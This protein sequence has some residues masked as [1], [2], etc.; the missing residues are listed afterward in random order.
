MSRAAA[1][2]LMELTSP[3]VLEHVVKKSRFIASASNVKSAA[4]ARAFI[5]LVRQPDASHNCWASRISDS[6][7]R[8]SDDGEPS[9]TAGKPIHGA[10]CFSDVKSVA[11]VVTRYFGG[12]KL[13][14]GGLVRAYNTAAARCLREAPKVNKP[15][16]VQLDVKVAWDKIGKVQAVAERLER[17]D[18]VYN[19]DG[20]TIT[21]RV[22]EEDADEIETRLTNVCG[23][24]VEIARSH[25]D[26]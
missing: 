23:G 13:G 19:D 11:V 12:V 20:C 18:S 16:M 24:K 3:F 25:G 22:P 15:P 14:A 1:K 6:E 7:S 4:D 9:G 10:I 17:V 8:Y 21:V 2:H 5:E 26:G